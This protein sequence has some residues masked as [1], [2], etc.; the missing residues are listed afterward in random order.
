MTV[1]A[2][3]YSERDGL[4]MA[5]KNP[6][7]MIFASKAEAD[8]RDKQLELAE[9][10][11]EFLTARVDGLSDELADRVALVMA[12]NKDLLARGLKKPSV[13]NQSAEDGND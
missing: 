7:T 8:A 4:E 13:L 6:D 9:E 3:Y 12:E 2:V 1:K 11:R 10:L 5:L